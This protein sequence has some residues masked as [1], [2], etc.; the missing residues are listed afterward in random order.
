[1]NVGLSV[2]LLCGAAI[3]VIGA[4][5]VTMAGTAYSDEYGGRRCDQGN[6]L[7]TETVDPPKKGYIGHDEPSVLFYSATAGAGNSQFYKLTLPKDPPTL[8]KQNGN[9]GT[10]NFQ[11]HPAFWFG[12][13]VCDEQ[14]APNF[15]HQACVPD[16][17]TN[18][19]DD[20]NPSSSRYIGKHPGTAFVEMQFYPPGWVTWPNGGDACDPF[21]WCAA[22]NIDS[23]SS[24]Q[25][26]NINNNAACQAS[27]GPEPV[28][29]AFITKSGIADSPGDP[30]NNLH[31][32]PNP[33]TDLFFNPGDTL[34][35]QMNDTSAGLKVSIKDLTTGQSG[36]MTA[37]VANGFAK[38]KFDPSAS[39]CTSIRSAFHPMYATSSEHTRATWTAHSY[40]VAFA[41]EIGHFEYC[42]KTDGNGHC[43]QAGV[44]D[45][46]GV[47]SDDARC[48][49]ASAS[50]RIKITGCADTDVDF[51]GV[52]YKKVWPGTLLSSSTDQSLHP[53]TV[54]FTSPLFRK[55]GGSAFN[56]NYSRVAFEADLPRIE[57]MQG[58][59][60][61]TGANC[62]NPPQGAN[63]Y[64]FYSAVSKNGSCT[65]QLGGSHIPGT[66]NLFGG[67]STT[68]FGSLL[69][70]VYPGFSRINDYRK[71]LSN[72]PC[73]APLK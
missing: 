69:N 8:P 19:F 63:F 23:F 34:T 14:S 50:S 42:A 18:I 70:V 60:R 9:G 6:P 39:T 47:D 61:T 38:I 30:Q 59:D 37:S 67:S 36:S 11:L 28:N 10:F 44:S 26:N 54:R 62:T 12:V 22:L 48:F 45:P 4:M 24:D 65:W 53:A 15:T 27:V 29:F 66:T 2:R 52:P 21:K 73:P 58:C 72:N 13:V 32:F 31:F 56:N 17:D 68:E 46:G 51:D 43:I 35:V 33:T 20:S 7:C 57:A 55:T 71:V 64:P 1:M 41:D 3:G 49:D 5:A 16:S 40:N 25:N